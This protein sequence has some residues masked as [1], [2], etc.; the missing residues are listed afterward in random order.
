MRILQMMWS[1]YRET[2]DPTGK[3]WHWSQMFEP[4]PFLPFAGVAV[5][6]SF[7]RI[8]APVE[9]KRY[10]KNENEDP[11]SLITVE[12]KDDFTLRHKLILSVL[13]NLPPGTKVQIHSHT[14]VH[15]IAYAKLGFT[16][17]GPIKNPKYP[18]AHID[19]L[20]ATR[21]HILEKITALLYKRAAAHSNP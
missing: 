17:I 19:L 13:Q 7:R 9:L 18:D 21:E 15:T 14:P 1:R 10:F 12:K 6:K 2:N 16:K 8:D 11:F 3:S 4:H 5:A 20:E